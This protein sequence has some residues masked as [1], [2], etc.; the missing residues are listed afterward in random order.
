MFYICY[1]I[2]GMNIVEGYNFLLIIMTVANI[3]LTDAC[4]RQI[5]DEGTDQST[6]YFILILY[7]LVHKQK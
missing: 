3:L 5:I 1:H 4:Y 7:S 2:S 6:A